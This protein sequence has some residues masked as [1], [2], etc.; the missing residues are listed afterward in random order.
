MSISPLTKIGADQVD[1]NRPCDVALA[2][3]KVQLAVVSGDKSETI[4]LGGERV[5]Y[6]KSN[7]SGLADLIRHYEGL[8]RKLNGRAGR[9]GAR[10]VRW[11]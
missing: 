2:L 6:T 11:R 10:P 9:R 5:T 1:I 4:E 3:R 8:C 7:A